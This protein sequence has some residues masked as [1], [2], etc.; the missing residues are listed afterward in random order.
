MVKKIV[1]AGIV[2]IF[3]LSG[4]V[5]P[6][7]VKAQNG[8]FGD[9]IGM[10]VTSVLIPSVQNSGNGNI[11]FHQLEQDLLRRDELRVVIKNSSD[12]TLYVSIDGEKGT[13]LVKGAKVTVLLPIPSNGE[14]WEYSILAEGQR[15]GEIVTA[16]RTVHAYKGMG[17][18][19]ENFIVKKYDLN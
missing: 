3:V 15:N 7:T 14:G 16:D 12:I 10:V 11:D 8:S 5:M 2:V 6:T 17:K 19:V 18:R 4:F 9:L 1:F 13:K